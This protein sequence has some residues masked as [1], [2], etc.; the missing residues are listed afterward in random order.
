V[1]A[2]Y[3]G[4]NCSLIVHG[5]LC[6]PAEYLQLHCVRKRVV[7]IV[8]LMGGHL[9][10]GMLRSRAARQR[11]EYRIVQPCLIGSNTIFT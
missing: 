11:A 9:G 5:R 6:G 4:S 2:R 1:N 8:H 10:K 3:S 7:Q